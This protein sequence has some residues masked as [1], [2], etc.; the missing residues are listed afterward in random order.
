MIP[1]PDQPASQGT[2]APAPPAGEPTAHLDSR[3]ALGA[4]GWLALAAVFALGGA[5]IVSATNQPPLAGKRPELTWTTDRQLDPALAKAA[6]DLAALSDDVD[7]LGAI[8]RRALTSLIDRDSAGISSA[9]ADGKTQL[10]LIAEATDTLRTRLAA[11]PGIG[12][13]DATRIGAA[14]RQRYDDLVLSLSATDGL[15]TSWNALTKSSL[16][17]MDLTKSLAEHDAEAGAAAKLGR[18]FHYKQALA[19]LDKADAALATTRQ[20]RDKL[21]NTTDVSILSSWIDRNAAFDGAVRKIWTLLVK[22]NGKVT[23]ANRAAVEA[24]FAEYRAAQAALPPDSRSLI[25]IMADVAR[26]GMNQAVIGIEEVRGRLSAAADA[27]GGG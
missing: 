23:K 22:S 7:A 19:T 3:R 18:A 1:R 4:L 20:L 2:I 12:P 25:V 10:D 13:D 6:G 5:G 17:A 9:L 16:A 8:G 11:I 24:A 27:L 21:A 15:A 26:G 14:V